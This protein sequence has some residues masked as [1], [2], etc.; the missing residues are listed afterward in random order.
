MSHVL[1]RS[2]LRLRENNLPKVTELAR[3]ELG[4]KYPWDGKQT[5]P[6]TLGFM[7]TKPPPTVGH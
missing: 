1:E 2:K 5:Q 7:V 3:M 4:F 6:V